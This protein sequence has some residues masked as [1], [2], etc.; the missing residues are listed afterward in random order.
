MN[1]QRQALQQLDWRRTEKV[2]GLNGYGMD[3]YVRNLSEAENSDLIQT[4]ML[5]EDGNPDPAKRRLFQ[6][7]LIQVCL[8]DE[9]GAPV[10][11]E[12]DSFADS[13]LDEILNMPAAMCETL[14]N[15]CLRMLGMDKSKD[16]AGGN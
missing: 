6:A 11:I 12:G 9:S 3:L 2:A 13:G 8:S 1:A 4:W 7:R 14:G 16:T 15:H 10:F 5:D